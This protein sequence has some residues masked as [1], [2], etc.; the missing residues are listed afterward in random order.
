MRHARPA[1]CHFIRPGRAFPPVMLPCG[2]AVC[3]TTPSPPAAQPTAPMSPVRAPRCNRR[4]ALA[5]NPASAAVN[6]PFVLHHRVGA[7]D[8]VRGNEAASTVAGV[9]IREN[10]TVVRRGPPDPCLNIVRQSGTLPYGLERGRTVRT[11]SNP[12]RARRRHERNVIPAPARSVPQDWGGGVV[13]AVIPCGV[14]GGR[15][16]PRPAAA[17]NPMSLW[18]APLVPIPQGEVTRF[19]L[20]VAMP[21]PLARSIYMVSVAESITAPAGMLLKLNWSRASRPEATN[22]CCPPPS[23]SWS[24]KNRV[25]LRGQSDIVSAKCRDSAQAGHDCPRDSKPRTGPANGTFAGRNVALARVGRKIVSSRLDVA[26]VI[27]TAR[28]NFITLQD[29]MIPH[30]CSGILKNLWH[31]L[32]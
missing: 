27:H 17:R 23:L 19:M 4:R 12:N 24:L 13:K 16:K 14:A 28:P 18:P 20:I 10:P 30:G 7:V 31:P 8:V 3:L 26:G 21:D 29:M 22:M 15:R 32:R 1:G 5:E 6:V 25:E 11:H 9:E 2:G